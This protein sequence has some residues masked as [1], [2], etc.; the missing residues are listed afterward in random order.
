MRLYGVGGLLCIGLRLAF[1]FL[2]DLQKTLRYESYGVSVVGFEFAVADG[3]AGIK[4]EEQAYNTVG[5]IGYGSHRTVREGRSPRRS[6]RRK[7]MLFSSMWLCRG[8]KH[9]LSSLLDSFAGL[10]IDVRQIYRN[11]VNLISFVPIF[12]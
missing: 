10:I 6:F 8:G 11:K 2:V 9:F 7:R 1:K 3:R 4:I 12:E 5:G